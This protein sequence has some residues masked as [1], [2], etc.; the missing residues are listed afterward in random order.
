[1]IT[2]HRPRARHWLA[3]AVLPALAGCSQLQ[4][5]GTALGLSSSTLQ[6]ISVASLDAGTL[7]CKYESTVAAVAGIKVNNATAAA[8]A[9]ACSAIT[10]AGTAQP[11]AVPVPPPVGATVVPIATV[12]LP[13]AAAVAASVKT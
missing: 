1:M 9:A 12:P 7:F 3:L 10:V 5:L 4:S 13:V 8:V 6:T 11:T 2:F